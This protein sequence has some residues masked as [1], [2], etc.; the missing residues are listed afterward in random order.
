VSTVPDRD[1][2]SVEGAVDLLGSTGIGPLWGMASDDLN[3]TLLSWPP[4]HGVA[5]HVN[6]EL[7]VLVVVLAGSGA[8]TVD[9]ERHEVGAG[10][11]ILV[12]HGASRSI[13]AAGDGL[14]Y[15]SVHR[16]RGPLQIQPA[17]L[18]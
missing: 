10:R 12:P 7:D 15:L 9:G 11:A 1:P 8:V 5:E 2:P 17:A 4:G 13:A 18:A 3:A 16:R 14:R 6:A